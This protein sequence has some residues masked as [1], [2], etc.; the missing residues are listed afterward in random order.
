MKLADTRTMVRALLTG[1]LDDAPTF[2]D[3]IFGLAV[4][5]S[6]PGVR[7]AIMNPRATWSDPAAYEAQARKL[8]EMFRK[9]FAQL[10]GE[11]SE[12]VRN[13]GPGR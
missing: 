7:P 4:P 10:G 8:A 13:A 2:T 11:V 5:K 12:S 1:A 3:D 6:V 9:N